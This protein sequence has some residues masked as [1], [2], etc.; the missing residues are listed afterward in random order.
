MGVLTSLFSSANQDS[1]NTINPKTD[2]P[3]GRPIFGD[4]NKWSPADIYFATTL[5]KNALKKLNNSKARKG[6]FLTFTDLNETVT[7][8]V[9]SGDLLPLSLKKAIGD[10][11]IKKVNFSRKYENK[12]LATTFG[13]GVQKWTKMSGSYKTTNKSFEWTKPYSGGRD[14]YI[15]LESGGK[16]GTLQIR[17]TPASG[18]KPSAG[19]KVILKYTGSAA[20][21]GQ[22][23]SIT[24]FTK[25]ISTVDPKFA[26]TI[27][28]VWDTQYMKFKPAALAYINY[29]GGKE[30]YKGDKKAKTKFNEDM[31]ALNGLTV[32]N[33]IRPLVENYF[34]KPDEEANNVI[35]AVFAYVA[36][37]TPN[38]AQF[39]IA[40]D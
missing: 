9:E 17:A 6:N 23:A 2:R 11:I 30:N 24:L 39:V 3:Y 38:S 21:G 35:R 31:G 14:I 37:R 27:Q 1:T 15:S 5:A 29:G 19:V 20:L 13:T 36:S 16:L 12:L 22:V 33:E 26:Q 10:V 40:K 32:M 4:L 34:K 7:L 8:L 28:R 18:G 25:I